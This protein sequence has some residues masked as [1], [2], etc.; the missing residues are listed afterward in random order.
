MAL[1]APFVEPLD[2]ADIET[3][4]A[5]R[6]A[7]YLFRMWREHEGLLI[8][9]ERLT[10]LASR[11]MTLRPNADAGDVPAI[12]FLGKNTPFRKY[13][14]EADSGGLQPTSLL[15]SS[16]KQSIAHGYHAA[17]N[18]EPWYDLQRTGSALGEDKP[19]LLI[20]RF[21]LKFRTHAGFE[22]LFC[23]TT[24]RHSCERSSQSNRRY[25][26]LSFQ[27]KSDWHPA[28]QAAAAATGSREMRLS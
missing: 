16:Y 2:L 11:L 22:R 25:H 8:Q 3:G 5:G 28:Y 7:Q 9:D 13:F 17:I 4:A 6:E 24:E 19:D 12:S 1:M 15:P 21:I 23:L 10:M 18:G 14:P 20:D 26:Q 27:Q